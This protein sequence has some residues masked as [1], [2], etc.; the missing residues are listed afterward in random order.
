MWNPIKNDAKEVIY[1][2]E[3]D[4]KISKP[5][6]CLPKGELGG[7]GINREVRI[8]IYIP[9]C[10]KLISNKDL[11]HSSGKFT[12]YSVIAYMGKDLKEERK[13]SKDLKKNYIY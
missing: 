5:N 4:S 2:I 7:R 1:K 8:G 11:L 6:F 3:I 13:I 9:L 10:T 12:Q